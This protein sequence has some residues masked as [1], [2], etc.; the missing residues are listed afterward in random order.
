MITPSEEYERYLASIAEETPSVLKMRLPAGENIYQ[1]NLN[2]RKIS[3]PPFIG[4]ESDHKAEY[5]FFEMDRFFD[6]IDLSEAIGMII[7]K[8]A[9]NEEYVQI[10]PY[11]DIYSHHNKILFPWAIQAPATLYEG[12]VS[13]SFKFFKI[14]PISKKIIYELNTLVAK[15]KV[16]VGWANTNKDIHTY[17]TID[18]E[19]LIVNQDIINLIN[20][21]ARVAKYQQVYWLEA[22][23]QPIENISDSEF[24]RILDEALPEGNG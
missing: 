21:A 16:L 17:A 3:P 8:N 7:F 19:S 9:K 22:D 6:L 4:V 15:T 12:T 11:Y 13:F 2:T 18:P 14:D 23:N 5:I 24:D 1:I 10:I 20:N